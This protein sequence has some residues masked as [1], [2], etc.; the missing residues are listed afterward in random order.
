MFLFIFIEIYVK[1]HI[2]RYH[3]VNVVLYMCVNT[4]VSE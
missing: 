1:R 4:L 3:N 2:T